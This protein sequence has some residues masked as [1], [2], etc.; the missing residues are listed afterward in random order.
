MAER[1][2]RER[3][4]HIGLLA[5]F[6]KK[7]PTMLKRVLF[8]YF[9]QT[10]HLSKAKFFTRVSVIYGKKHIFNTM[11]HYFIRRRVYTNEY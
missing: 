8:P 11:F 5:R 2:K 1:A 9:M 10:L 6:S 4:Q 7:N 3:K